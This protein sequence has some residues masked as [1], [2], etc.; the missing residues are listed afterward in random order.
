MTTGIQTSGLE[1]GTRRREKAIR[2][3]Q[4][5]MPSNPPS[6]H[7]PMSL[8]P[9]E[10]ALFIE[11]E[12]NSISTPLLEPALP[13]FQSKRVPPETKCCPSSLFATIR[14]MVVALSVSAGSFLRGIHHQEDVQETSAIPGCRR[15][16][17]VF[18]R[19]SPVRRRGL[20]ASIQG[21]FPGKH[22]PGFPRQSCH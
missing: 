1:M 7:S 9:K 5:R 15:R 18:R 20:G 8:F 12:R 22:A 3:R 6:L 2:S 4:A 21:R 17:S 10:E 19:L 11:S 16:R 13:R 14:D